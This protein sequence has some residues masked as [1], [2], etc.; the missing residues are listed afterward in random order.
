MA[1]F[2]YCIG[3]RPGFT[4][5]TAACVYVHSPLHCAPTFPD[6][7]ACSSFAHPATPPCLR[8]HPPCPQPRCGNNYGWSEFEGSR[9]QEAQEDRDGDCAGRSRSGFTFPYFEYCHPDYNSDTAAEQEFTAGVDICGDRTL[10]GH[11]VIGAWG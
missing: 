10:I 6:T 7:L 2:G 9:C 3:D 4:A 8:F 11:A 1:G 5:T